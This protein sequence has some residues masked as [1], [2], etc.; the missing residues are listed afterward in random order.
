MFETRNVGLPNVKFKIY[1]VNEPASTFSDRI[2]IKSILDIYTAWGLCPFVRE[3]GVV[4]RLEEL[5]I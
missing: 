5:A 3:R 4:D 2:G 1:V